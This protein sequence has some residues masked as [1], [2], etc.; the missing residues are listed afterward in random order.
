MKT[1]VSSKNFRCLSSD[2]LEDSFSFSSNDYYGEKKMVCIGLTTLQK[3]VNTLIEM[4]TSIRLDSLKSRLDKRILLHTKEKIILS[5]CT[6]S[7]RKI[8]V[9]PSLY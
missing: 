7:T 2:L 4:L 9:I 8:Q 3:Y 6:L 1:N 5:P